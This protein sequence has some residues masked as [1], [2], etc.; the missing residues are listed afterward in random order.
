MDLQSDVTRFTT[1]TFSVSRGNHLLSWTYAK[2]EG[3]SKGLD[4]AILSV[5]EPPLLHF[6]VQCVRSVV[7]TRE[8]VIEIKGLR[9]AQDGACSKCPPGTTSQAG[10][11]DCEMCPANYVAA[12]AGSSTCEPCPSDQY[13]LPGSAYCWPR[14]R[15]LTPTL[16]AFACLGLLLAKRLTK[17]LAAH[18][19][20]P[21]ALLPLRLLRVCKWV[22]VQGL[23]VVPAGDL[24]Y[25][26]HRPA[27]AS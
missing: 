9:Y 22:T 26:E 12:E 27:I 5:R 23:G 16:T 3:Q 19:S 11:G 15:T 8:Q 1:R 7:L 4:K 10:A 14:A 18:Y 2:D 6:T 24:Q 13:A 21:S 25:V 17:V 20:L